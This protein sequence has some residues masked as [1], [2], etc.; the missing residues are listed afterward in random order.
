MIS[1][2]ASRSIADRVHHHPWSSG[3][4]CS[5][6]TLIADRSTEPEL[7]FMNEFTRQYNGSPVDLHEAACST[8]PFEGENL[9]EPDRG[10][11]DSRP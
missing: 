4:S 5:D 6:W 2:A 3:S 1:M 8:A 11:G 10:D 7:G 9:A